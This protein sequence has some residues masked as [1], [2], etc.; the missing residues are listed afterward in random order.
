MNIKRELHNIE[1]QWQRTYRKD[2]RSVT[3]F[4]AIILNISVASADWWDE[5]NQH[6]EEVPPVVAKDAAGQLLEQ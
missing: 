4:T 6:K 3:D 2:N 1:T 5:N